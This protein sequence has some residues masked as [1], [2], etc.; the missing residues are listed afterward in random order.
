MPLCLVDSQTSTSSYKEKKLL[1]PS[2]CPSLRLPTWA[3]YLELIP[4]FNTFI[5][6]P[7]WLSLPYFSTKHETNL[8]FSRNHDH[9]PWCQ[10]P[11]W[12]KI[13]TPNHITLN[14]GA[15]SLDLDFVLKVFHTFPPC[16]L[17]YCRLYLS[18]G[19]AAG[20]KNHRTKWTVVIQQCDLSCIFSTE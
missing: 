1:P 5:A 17:N 6:T 8:F 3:S 20:E 15:D 9:R 13:L 14:E 7:D 19:C 11:I 18:L 10:V 12:I 2:E 16:N 4:N